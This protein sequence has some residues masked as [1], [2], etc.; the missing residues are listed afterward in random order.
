MV[1]KGDEFQ[2]EKKELPK[3]IV[4]VENSFFPGNNLINSYS[5]FVVVAVVEQLT[6][7]TTTTAFKKYF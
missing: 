4:M 3:K 5:I 6:T 1:N 2:P 7:T